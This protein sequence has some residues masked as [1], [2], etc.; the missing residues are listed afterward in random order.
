MKKKILDMKTTIMKT[1]I[2]NIKVKNFHGF[3]SCSFSEKIV[4]LIG[5]IFQDGHGLIIW[6]KNKNPII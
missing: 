5:H 4:V 3:L 2:T 6:R 1:T